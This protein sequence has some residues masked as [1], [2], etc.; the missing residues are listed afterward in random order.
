MYTVR[1]RLLIHVD[2]NVYCRILVNISALHSWMVY[3]Y[4]IFSQEQTAF[5]RFIV[6]I[7]YTYMYMYT[8]YMYRLCT[9]W[10]YI[11]MY[12]IYCHFNCVVELELR[13][14]VRAHTLCEHKL[15]YAPMK[16][17]CTWLA[18]VSPTLAFEQA[19]PVTCTWYTY[20]LH[21]HVYSR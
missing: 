4:Y 3:I 17:Q 12:M 7:N 15:Q 14:S 10:L 21:L 6:I 11:Y 16:D 8:V 18:L 19:P 2:V 5:Y 9:I 13:V 20:N 1:L